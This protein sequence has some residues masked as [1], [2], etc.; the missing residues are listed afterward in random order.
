[1]RQECNSS[2]LPT[3]E[4]KESYPEINALAKYLI[5]ANCT[6]ADAITG[7]NTFVE[8]YTFD[9]VMIAYMLQFGMFMLGC[10]TSVPTPKGIV[11]TT[12]FILY[13]TSLVSQNCCL[14]LGLA[15]YVG[16]FVSFASQ[17]GECLVGSGHGMSLLSWVWLFAGAFSPFVISVL[18]L[19]HFNCM[20]LLMAA[21]VW[22][23]AR[24][25][26][27]LKLGEVADQAGLLL[28]NHF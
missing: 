17:H 23:V 14:V 24:Y 26:R 7:M 2:F 13:F 16:S 1:M 4:S 20:L 3:S 18:L 10:L 27:D 22:V 11:G 6:S 8:Q 9:R 12:S 25:E 15:A 19:L 5:H 21:R 28:V